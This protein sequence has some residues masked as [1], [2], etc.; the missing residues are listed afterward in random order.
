MSP[1]G[2]YQHR[3]N[4]FVCTDKIATGAVRPRNDKRG[5]L[6]CLCEEGVS[7]TW[8]SIFYFVNRE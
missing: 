1:P 6:L 8:Q 4:Q 3:T 7:P 2:N 5:R